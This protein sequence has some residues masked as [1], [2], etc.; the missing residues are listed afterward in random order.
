M[1]FEFIQFLLQALL[2]FGVIGFIVGLIRKPKSRP[3]FSEP[4]T[5]LVAR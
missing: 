5:D 4:S 2:A 3:S 1:L